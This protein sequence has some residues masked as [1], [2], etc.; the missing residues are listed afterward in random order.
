M[1]FE[2][3]LINDPKAEMRLEAGALLYKINTS[4]PSIYPSPF[5]YVPHIND[6]E[7]GFYQAINNI[8]EGSPTSMSSSQINNLINCNKSSPY[9]KHGIVEFAEKHKDILSYYKTRIE[10]LERSEYPPNCD[11]KRESASGYLSRANVSGAMSNTK[12]SAKEKLENLRNEPY[13]SS[14]DIGKPTKNYPLKY[15]LQ[16]EIDK[17]NKNENQRAKL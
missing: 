14:V 9:A 1:S 10:K 13:E 12:E 7:L 6:K 4:G 8:A 15:K 11:S 17:V 3:I 5:K 2:H 16:N